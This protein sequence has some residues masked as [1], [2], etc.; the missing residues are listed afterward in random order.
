M[1]KNIT[2]SMIKP[3]GVENGHIGSIIS[4]IDSA[5]FN[6]IALKMTQ[7]SRKKAESFYYIHKDRPFFQDL[8]NFI[9]R[10]PIVVMVLEKADAVNDFRTL[11]GSTDPNEAADGTIRRLYATSKG[12]NVIHGSDSDENAQIES[13]F[14]FSNCE[15][16]NEK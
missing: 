4:K 9:I 10:G 1:L 11:I 15:L 2:F 5:G 13:F 7:L 3:D 14:H 8:I 12:E 16:F 6:I